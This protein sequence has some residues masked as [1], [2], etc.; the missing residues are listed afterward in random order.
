MPNISEVKNHLTGLGGAA[1][2]DDVAN[3]YQLLERASNTMLAKIDPIETERIAALSSLVYDDVY[4]YALPSDYKKIIDLYPQVDRGSWDRAAR[5]YAEPFDAQKLI[6]EKQITIESSEGTKFIRINWRTRGAKIL[7]SMNSLTANGTWSA[8]GS[9]TGLKAQTLF[10]VSGNASIEFDLVATGD[11]IQNTAMTALDLTDEDEI[12]DVFVWV[13]LPSAPT[14]ITAI[15]GNDLTTNYWTGVAQTAQAD[16]TAFKVG[17]NLIKFPWS[18]AT[19]TGTVAPATIDS[20]RLTVSSS[21]ALTNVRVDDIKFVV[22]RNFDIKY[23][24]QYS[25]KNAGGTWIN[26]PTTDA[27]TLIHTG[28]AYQIFLLESRIAIAQQLIKDPRS[29]LSATLWERVQLNG[30][31]Q[32]TDRALRLG[33]YAYYRSEYPSM[34]KKA[35]TSYAGLPRFLLRRIS[36]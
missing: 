7:H 27:D 1:S 5:K 14:S 2:V 11:G 34:S 10:K 20:F 33:L 19:E 17:W 16:G 18:T 4:D 13:Y 30:D 12:A 23:Y 36:G 22:G 29:A 31:I 21:S 25:F 35:T 26:Q 8:V 6:K 32:A 9:A 24:S 28:T 15:W 3:L